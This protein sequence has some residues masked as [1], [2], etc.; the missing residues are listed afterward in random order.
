MTVFA[1]YVAVTLILIFALVEYIGNQKK[2]HAR[3]VKYAESL[4]DAVVHHLN[5]VSRLKD[6]TDDYEA[7]LLESEYLI[8]QARE[9]FK[10]LHGK[11]PG[12]DL[13]DLSINGG[14]VGTANVKNVFTKDELVKIRF[15]IHPDRNGGKNTELFQKINSMVK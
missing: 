10:A 7:A 8:N 3:Q 13:S 2:V 15:S 6:C 4:A 11:D 14:T 9:N 5:E 12:E 1:V